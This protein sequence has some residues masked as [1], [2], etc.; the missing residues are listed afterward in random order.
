VV[1]RSGSSAASGSSKSWNRSRIWPRRAP[2]LRGSAPSSW[3]AASDVAGRLFP[4]G[5][6]SCRGR[7]YL[8]S[9]PAMYAAM[10]A[11]DIFLLT[12]R[13]PVASFLSLLSSSGSSASSAARSKASTKAS[14]LSSLGQMPTTRRPRSGKARD[15]SVLSAHAVGGEGFEIASVV[16]PDH[17]PDR[18]V[19][20]DSQLRGY[21]FG[22]SFSLVIHDDDVR[23]AAKHWQVTS[24]P[25]IRQ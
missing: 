13:N 20:F 11:V 17:R 8:G 2:L 4:P 18:V 10:T 24:G 7:H 5:F 12:L 14:T 19:R 15:K 6:L 21:H 25:K 16:Q 9:W 1:G 23:D 3:E 22:P